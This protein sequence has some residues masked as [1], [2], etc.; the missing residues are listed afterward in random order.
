MTTVDV[1]VVGAGLAGLAAAH[2]LTRAGLAVRVLEARDRVGGRVVNAELPNGGV[3]EMGGEYTGPRQHAILQLAEELGV[4]T[5][6][7]YDAGDTLLELTGA[8]SRYRGT[9]PRVE[10]RVLL[11]L[12]QAQLRLEWMARSV[13]LDAPWTAR[14]SPRWDRQGL[15]AWLDRNM[16]TRRG[17]A[18]MLTAIEVIWPVTGDIS[19]LTALHYIRFAGGLEALAG[20]EG[21]AQESRFV[22]GSHE[23]AQRLADRLADRVALG[24][25]VSAIRRVGDAVHVEASGA[26]VT[27][28]R[29]LVAMSPPLYGRIEFDPPLPERRRQLTQRMAQGAVIKC[30]AVYDRPFWREAGLN[31]QAVSDRGPASV[32]VDNSPLGGF[33]GVLLGFIVG[34]RAR[35]A[36]EIPADDR[37]RDLLACFTRLFG[38]EARSPELYIEQDWAAEAYSGGCYAAVFE[39]GGWI[40]LGPELRAPLGRIHW[41]GAETAS[42]WYGYMDGAVASGRRAAREILD[43]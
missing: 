39:P 17:R 43:L 7:T 20:I 15:R 4:D 10:R 29:A 35:R 25:P 16:R 36:A 37:R 11:D 5:F 14:R 8:I 24:A 19:L 12:A 31:G 6:P 23:I 1:A 18:L 30:S 13:P 28:R 40:E 41:A 33:P 34:S 26:G 9:I 3:T 32:V 38:A 22:G 2:D 21:G 27:A 42:A